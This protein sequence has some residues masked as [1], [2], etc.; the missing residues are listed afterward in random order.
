MLKL[1]RNTLGDKKSFCDASHGIIQWAYIERLHSLQAKE[2]LHAGNKL[3]KAHIEWQ[4][5]KMKV[6]LAAQTLSESTAAA[7]EFCDK[8]LKLTEFTGCEATVRFIRLIDR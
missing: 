2:G 6:K 1:V 8:D 3:R 7:L 5:M 4:Q